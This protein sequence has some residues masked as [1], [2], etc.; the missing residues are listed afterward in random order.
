MKSY[1]WQFQRALFKNKRHPAVMMTSSSSKKENV[2]DYPR[3]PRLE[4]T[5]KHLKVL[6]KGKV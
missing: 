6:Y 5:K 4:P 2:W 1:I 3:P